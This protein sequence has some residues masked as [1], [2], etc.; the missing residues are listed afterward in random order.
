[1]NWKLYNV[2]KLHR[3]RKPM[4]DAFLGDSVSRPTRLRL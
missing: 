2:R 3:P 4:S 1:M